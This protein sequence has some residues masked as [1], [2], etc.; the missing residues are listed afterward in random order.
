MIWRDQWGAVAARIEGLLA[1]GHFFVQT[2]RVNSEDQYGVSTH[3]GNQARDIAS[4]IEVYFKAH[5]A[6]LPPFAAASISRFLADLKPK[7]DTTDVSGL[8]ALKLKLTS[9]AWLRAEVDYHLSD[10]TALARRRSERAF[11]HLQQTIAADPAHRQRWQ[12]AFKE[13]EVACECLGG[14]HLL[15]HGIYAFKVHGAGAR[16]DLVFNE[17]LDDVTKVQQVAEAL[18]LTEWKLVSS[19]QAVAGA[20]A[21]ARRQAELY[22]GGVLGG[23]ELADYRYVVVVT[24]DRVP[25]PED[26]A[27]SRATYRHVNIAVA[28][29]VPS[30]AT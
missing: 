27:G 24:Q 10:F 29:S 11:T 25:M 26:A 9:L 19:T 2:L 6:A 18:V 4:S 30:W 14:A 17:P 15:L 21:S 13:G 20:A 7:I 5:Q 3:L 1:A 16:T 28:P 22:A 8:N 23:L 12:A